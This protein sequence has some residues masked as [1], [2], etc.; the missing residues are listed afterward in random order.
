MPQR[1]Q[2]Q[3]SATVDTSLPACLRS[4]IQPLQNSM[5]LQHRNILTLQEEST[6]RVIQTVQD[7]SQAAV[8][9]IRSRSTES[10]NATVGLQVK[11]EQISSVI[12]SIH[13]SLQRLPL[14]QQNVIT[15]HGDNDLQKA[16]GSILQSILLLVSGLQQLTRALLW[17]FSLPLY[18]QN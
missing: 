6:Q 5:N 17:V 9:L 3:I 10:R 2:E 15:E 16:M 8:E 13:R 11:L 1:I 18:Y 4:S 14:I 12:F 7:H